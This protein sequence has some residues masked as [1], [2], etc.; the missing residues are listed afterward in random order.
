MFPTMTWME[1]NND[2]PHVRQK[3]ERLCAKAM[4]KFPE[5][6]KYER[7]II[8]GGPH[9]SP[10]SNEEHITVRMK[11]ATQIEDNTFH[12]G[13]VDVDESHRYVYDFVIYKDRNLDDDYRVEYKKCLPRNNKYRSKRSSPW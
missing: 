6:C 11:T 9:K 10:S 12:M 8:M 3:S 5:Y 2:P 4:R 1:S 7:M 13:H